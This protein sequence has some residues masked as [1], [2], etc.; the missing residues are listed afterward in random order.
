MD[1]SE[2]LATLGTQGT[3]RGHTMYWT[4]AH[5]V[6]NESTQGT[7]R[8]HTRY[9]TRTHK[10]LDED[11]QNTTQKTKKMSNTDSTKYRG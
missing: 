7:G 5:K 8:G 9:W 4:R 2:T 10:I 1:N 11:N 3:G 6:L